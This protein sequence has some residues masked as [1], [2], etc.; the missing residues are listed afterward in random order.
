MIFA[1]SKLYVEALVSSLLLLTIIFIDPLES[2]LKQWW[3]R[4]WLRAQARLEQGHVL[5]CM[6]RHS[7]YKLEITYSYSVAGNIYVGVYRESFSKEGD[8]VHLL[9]NLEQSPFQV[10]VDPTNLNRSV[11]SPYKDV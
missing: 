1:C 6:G 3:S 2:L 7:G 9:T 5:P 8:A 11:L 4:Y 10:R